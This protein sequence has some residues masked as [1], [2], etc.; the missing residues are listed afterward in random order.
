MLAEIREF[1]IARQASP[2]DVGTCLGQ[3]HLIAMPR[4]ADAAGAVD[5][6]ADVVIPAGESLAGV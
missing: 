5:L 1:D 6:M 3:D 4:G 2:H